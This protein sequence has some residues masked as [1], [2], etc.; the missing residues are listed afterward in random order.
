MNSSIKISHIRNLIN[1]VEILNLEGGRFVPVTQF[2]PTTITLEL[3]DAYIGHDQ[4][5]SIVGQIVVEDKSHHFEAVAKV[6]DSEVILDSLVQF[7]FQLSQVQSQ[8]WKSFLDSKKS[9]QERVDQLLR[10]MKGRDPVE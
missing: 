6:I 7:E 3:Y 9:A 8:L 4:L 5:V 1:H 10:K 2:T